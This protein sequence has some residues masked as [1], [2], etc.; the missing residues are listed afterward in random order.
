MQ[1]TV[2]VAIAIASAISALVLVYTIGVMP[3]QAPTA[4]TSGNNST[5]ITPPTLNRTIPAPL[6]IPSNDTL[7]TPA[8]LLHVVITQPTEGAKVKGAVEA[9][10]QVSGDVDVEM[11]EGYLNDTL[12][13][14][15]NSA[16][17]E[18]IIPTAQFADGNYKFMA[19]AIG[20]NGVTASSEVSIT[21]QNLVNLPPS[22]TYPDPI[23]LGGILPSAEQV[24]ISETF[25]VPDE[26]S[27]YII[28]IPNEGHHLD[29]EPDSLIAQTNA[30][31]LP[32]HV[33]ISKTTSITLLSNDHDHFHT[34]VVASE[35]DGTVVW[36]TE[37]IAYAQHSESI[38]F[39]NEEVGTF[40]FVDDDTD[41]QDMKG[42]ITIREAT[43]SPTAYTVGAI[44]VPQEDLPMFKQTLSVRGFAIESEHN[45]TWDNSNQDTDDQTLIV[46]STM[47]PLSSALQQ[48]AIIVE[49]TPYD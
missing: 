31:Y 28:L 7:P 37:N 41:Y 25:R 33:E 19:K 44:Y 9:V 11:V 38:S 15:E 27:N 23:P 30:H 26:V 36:E 24:F 32:I 18:I 34:T 29:S 46:F 5:V 14:T 48:L 22:G 35:K 20:D 49:Q 39:S 16:P 45:F 6:P 1:P 13:D 40:L 17:Y 3:A 47:Q 21:I 10:V 12:I 43:R 2:I 4:V 8:P 42:T